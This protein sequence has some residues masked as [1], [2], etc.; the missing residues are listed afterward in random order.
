MILVYTFILYVVIF[1]VD[2]SQNSDSACI[3][4]QFPSANICQN[5]LENPFPSVICVFN[6]K[7]GCDVVKSSTHSIR[8]NKRL[9]FLDA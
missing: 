5:F 1:N 8:G 3:S 2:A 6:L 7:S 4:A 9:Q